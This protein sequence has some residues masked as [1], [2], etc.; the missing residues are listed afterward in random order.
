M[1]QTLLKRA[2]EFLHA[3]LTVLLG[4]EPP[5]TF[6]S[7]TLILSP[8][9]MVGLLSVI[10]LFASHSRVKGGNQSAKLIVD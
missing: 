8:P 10:I 3:A 7:L 9:Q 6:T 5:I 1:G 2:Q 4:P